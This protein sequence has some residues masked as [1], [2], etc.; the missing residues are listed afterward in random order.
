MRRPTMTRSSLT[1]RRVPAPRV[2]AF[3]MVVL[4]T[5]ALPSAALAASAE[6]PAK[7]GEA[8]KKTFDIADGDAARTLK[9]FAAQSG[10]QLLYAPEDVAA[11]KTAAVRGQFAPREALD[12][13]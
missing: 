11:V 9:Q 7:A 12:R 5:L 1:P 6:D 3:R 13:M 8:A 2:R 10:E 4:F